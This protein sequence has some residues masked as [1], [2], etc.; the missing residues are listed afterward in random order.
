MKPRAGAFGVSLSPIAPSQNSCGDEQ[1]VPEGE[2]EG[3]RASGTGEFLQERTHVGGERRADLD[4]PAFQGVEEAKLRSVKQMS[5]RV[6]VSLPI[7]GIRAVEGV[8]HHRTA[9]KGEVGPKLVPRTCSHPQPHERMP[10]VSTKDTEV[11][12]RRTGSPKAAGSP[13]FADHLNPVGAAPPGCDGAVYDS[14]RFGPTVYD[15]EVD[16]HHSALF[17]LDAKPLEGR[18]GASGQQ[19]TRG[20]PVETVQYAGLPWGM[21]DALHLRISRCQEIG[22]G[23]PLSEKQGMGRHAGRLVYG[24]KGCIRP[25]NPDRQVG[26]RD[27]RLFGRQTRDSQIQPIPFVQDRPLPCGPSVT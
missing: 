9:E 10:P 5:A 2:S 22:Q 24:D 13:F 18:I 11:C 1:S 8:A 14:L 12:F 25:E 26:L 15:R 7:F 6:S 3:S 17:E 21:A 19:H 4:R 23:V 27:D 20:V 16:L